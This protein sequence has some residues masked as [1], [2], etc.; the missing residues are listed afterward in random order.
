MKERPH[1]ASYFIMYCLF[2][3]AVTGTDGTELLDD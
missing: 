1:F 2:N 3:D